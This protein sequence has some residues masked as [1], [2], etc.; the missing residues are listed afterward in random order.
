[1][2]VV[3]VGLPGSG[4]SA[5]GRRLAQRHGTRLVDLDELIVADAGQTIA[6]IFAGEGEPGFRARERAA[7]DA[8]GP[9][10]GSDGVARVIATGGG[11]VVDPGNRWRLYRGRLPVWLD[12]RPEVLAQ[13][14]RRSPHERPLIA[15]R[16]PIGAVRSLAAARERF[17]AAAPR[18][19]SVSEVAAV[20]EGVER[21]C[22]SGP[23]PATTLLRAQTRIGRF[24]IGDGIA[25]SALV[26]ELAGLGA[27]RAVVVSEP[28]AWAACGERIAATVAESGLRVETITLPRG[29]DA[30]RLSVI[31]GAA[32][33]LARLRVERSEPLVA[34]G[35]GALGDAAGFLAATYLRG[36]PIVHIPTTLVAQIDSSIGGKTGI[37]HPAGKNLIGAYHQPVA[38]YID[39]DYLRTLPA[40]QFRAGLAEV[41]KC[42]VVA[43]YL[44]K[45]PK[46]KLQIEG[47]CDERGTAEYNMAL[48][49]RRATAVMTYLV[50]L[51]VSKAALSTV[52]F[53]KE[54]PLDPGHDEEAWAKN[55]R[56]AF[57]ILKRATD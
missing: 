1:M 42:G 5:V 49:D 19:N 56:V 9:P 55:R 50:S 26:A 25:A 53:G 32:R 17:Y 15:G 40:R 45:H 10:D 12:A 30:K 7:V 47:H 48:G 13:R 27:A 31:E 41:V 37:N 51:G 36:V 46:A 3:L 6:E 52:S 29:E 54:K 8:L 57:L 23:G 43:D 38:I 18:V 34:I 44:K 2:D 14:L 11:A 22:A 21:L 20:V 4:K 33:E 35:G 28:G 39:I 24:V 16:D